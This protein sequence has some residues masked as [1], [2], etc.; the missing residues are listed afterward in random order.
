MAIIKPNTSTTTEDTDPYEKK[1]LRF[2]C[3]GDGASGLG[4]LGGDGGGEGVTADVVVG[5]ALSVV[6]SQEDRQADSEAAAGDLAVVV[7]AG[8]EAVWVTA[9]DSE[10]WTALAAEWATAAQTAVQMLP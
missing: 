5:A 9:A 7:V 4:C 3:T 10:D 2:C 8:W 6:G 1:C